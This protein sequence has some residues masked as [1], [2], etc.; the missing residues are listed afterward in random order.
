MNFVDGVTIIK[1]LLHSYNMKHLQNM[2]QVFS[3]LIIL[4]Y[5]YFIRL[6]NS[7]QNHG[8]KIMSSFAISEMIA[9]DAPLRSV[10]L[11]DFVF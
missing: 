8:E 7:S 11:N 2:I 4:E 10:F 1:I 9:S 3:C 5:W 6:V